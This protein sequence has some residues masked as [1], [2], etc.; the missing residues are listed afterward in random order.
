MASKARRPKSDRDDA[1]EGAGVEL[2]TWIKT[3]LVSHTMEDYESLNLLAWLGR[4]GEVG[5]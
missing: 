5:L 4:Y 3:L 2:R 1:V